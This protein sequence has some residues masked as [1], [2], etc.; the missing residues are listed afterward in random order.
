MENAYWFGIGFVLG[1]VL[2]GFFIIYLSKY[3]YNKLAQDL[4]EMDK[5]AIITIVKEMAV[6]KAKPE[7]K[8][9]EGYEEFGKQLIKRL[10]SE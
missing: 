5:Q 2:V 9:E 10:E 1:S 6:F 8:W 4:K 7:G 3:L